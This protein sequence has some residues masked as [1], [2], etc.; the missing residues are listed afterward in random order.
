MKIL[1]AYEWCQIGGVEAFMVGLW[2]ELRA[3]GHQCE[4]FF[5]ERG[6]MAEQLPAG[7]VAHFGDLSDCMKLVRE[8][9]FD[10]VHANSSDWRNGIAAVRTCGARLVITAH[11]MVVRGWNST[12]CDALVCCSQWQADEQ[13]RYTDLPVQTV[14]NGIDT[15]LFK[16]VADASATDADASIA[17][18]SSNNATEA[19]APGIFDAPSASAPIVAWVGRANDMVHKRIDR[20]AAVAPALRAAGVRIW[21]ADPTGFAEVEAVAP[22]AARTL[23]PLAEVWG[24]VTKEK[25]PAFFRA[26]ATS[27]G[28]VLST[29]VREGL[30]MALI[31]AQACGCPV[32]GSDVRGVNEVVRPEHGGLLYP[33]G[34]EA[35]QLA[36]LLLDT[37]GDREAMRERREACA[38]FAHEQF[39][40][41]RMARDYTRIYGEALEARSRRSARTHARLWLAPLLDWDDYVERRWTA[42]V[43]QY[44]TSRKLAGQG[45]RALAA[46]AARLSFVTCP[47]IYARPAR[48]AHLLKILLRPAGLSGERGDAIK[49]VTLK[50]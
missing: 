18:T 6:P 17:F 30:P 15:N 45:E 9:G 36:K 25:L 49:R 38:R 14:L 50:R 12:N 28:C 46:A 4:F 40:L 27:G 47:T 23:R 41:R 20:L 34:L 39:S 11:G 42:G 32:V 1:L 7:S 2:E 35:D 16:P 26:V 21:I 8:R 10:I 48:L 13:T 5:F 37:L 44:E 43:R 33:F 29:S 19:S 31:E 3:A 22:D 24:A